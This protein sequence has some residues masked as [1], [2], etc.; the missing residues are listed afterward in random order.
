MCQ[1][2]GVEVPIYS[3]AKTVADC[4]KHRRHVGED[5]AI[6]AL[7]DALRLNERPL[8]RTSCATPRSTGSRT[9]RRPMSRR[10]ND[11]QAPRRI[12]AASIRQRLL[13]HAKA[14]GDDYQRILT[15]YAIER[16]LFRIEPN[17]GARPAI[18]SRAP[19]CS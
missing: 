7:R 6:E 5:V 14:N 1:I 4:F 8:S 2:E 9:D 3:V 15:R 13:N 19:C 18:S 11:S 12:P 16:L 17:R 10:C